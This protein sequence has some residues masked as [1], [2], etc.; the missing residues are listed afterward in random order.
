MIVRGKD[1]LGESA[2]IAGSPSVII[3]EGE[4]LWHVVSPVSI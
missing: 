4:S 3:L 1:I 2:E